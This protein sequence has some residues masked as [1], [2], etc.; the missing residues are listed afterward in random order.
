M[1]KKANFV[2]QRIRVTNP[3]WA[4]HTDGFATGDTV[5]ITDPDHHEI[6][7][8]EAVNAAG[9]TSILY[10]DEFEVIPQTTA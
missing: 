9:K 1:F 10:A 5:T 8:V 3:D 4:H 7:V 6:G 2:G